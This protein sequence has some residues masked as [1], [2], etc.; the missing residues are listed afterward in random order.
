MF[1]ISSERLGKIGDFFD[2]AAAEKDGVNI[3]ALIAG[4][5]LAETST[6]TETKPAKTDSEQSED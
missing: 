6:K 4:G 1:K 3:A 2:A 5:F